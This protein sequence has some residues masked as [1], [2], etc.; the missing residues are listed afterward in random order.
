MF[1]I[2]D[3]ALEGNRGGSNCCSEEGSTDGVPN[4]GVLD[5]ELAPG[6]WTPGGARLD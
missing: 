6:G 1:I 3:L 5:W 4:G 2:R